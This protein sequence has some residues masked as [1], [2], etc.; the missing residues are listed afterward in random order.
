MDKIENELSFSKSNV[1]KYRDAKSNVPFIPLST[2]IIIELRPRTISK[3]IVL[4]NIDIKDGNTDSTIDC[5]VVGYGDGTCKVN[6]GDK[7]L[8]KHNSFGK[9]LSFKGEKFQTKDD[10]NRIVPIVYAI[11]SEIDLWGIYTN[12]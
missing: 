6:I 12:S 10:M 9:K 7:V 2:S 4:S 11:I 5:I 8:C 1:T 3:L